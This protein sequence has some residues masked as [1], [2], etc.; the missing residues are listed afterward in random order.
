M[1]VDISAYEIN[2]QPAPAEAFTAAACDPRY[3]VVVEACAGSGKTWLLVA[4]MLRLLLAGAK[5]AELLAITFTRKAAQEMRE[6]LMEL[7]HE[8]TLAPAEQARQLLRERGVSES[9]LARVMPLARSLYEQILSGQQSLSIDTFHSWFAR[10]LQLAPLASGVPHGY[11]LTDKNGELMNEAYRRFMQAIQKPAQREQKDAL[12]A[13]YELAGDSGA[14]R[15]LDAFLDKRAE[16]WAATMPPLSSDDAPLRWLQDLC[17]ND[18]LQD[19]RLQVWQDDTLKA[20]LL[21]VAAILGK[22][23]SANQ[24]RA[25]TI[26]TLVS[27]EAS[28]ENFAALASQFYDDNDKPRGNNT[29]TK[30]LKAALAAHFS[31]DEDQAVTLFDDLFDALG[32]TLRDLQLRSAEKVVVGLNAALF[33]AGRTYLDAYQEVKA[34]QRVFDFADLEW[35]AYRLLT[36]E[37]TAA[38]LQSRLDARYKHILLDEF[39]DTNPLQWSIV[40]AWLRAY[41]DDTMQP[42]V[43][44]VGD[45]KQSIY[46]FRRAEPRVF[47]AARS[48]LEQ[49]GALVLRANQTRRNASAIVGFLNTS[50]VGRNPLFAAQTTLGL[51]GGAVWRLPLVQAPVLDET[52]AVTSATS[53]TALR[54]PLTTPRDEEDD[55][56]RRDEGRLVAQAILQ[57]RRQLRVPGQQG[58]RSLKWSD[59]MLLVKKRR[60]L[61]SYE[62][63]LREAGI[64]FISDKRGGLLDALEIADLIALLNFLI[65]PNDTRALAHVLKSPIIG[66]SDRDL[67]V[68][69][70]RPEPH[71]W[72]RLQAQYRLGEATPPMARAATLLAQWLQAAPRY[73]V[74]DLLDM[75]LHQGQLVARYAQSVAPAMRAQTIGNIESFVELALNLDAGRFPSLPK[76]IDALASLQRHADSD[77]PD[78]ASVDAAADAV[79][80]LTVHSAKGLEAPVVIM[81]DTNHSDPATDNIGIL[82]DWPQDQ[83]APTHFSAFGRKSER[84]LARSPWFAAE[85][86]FRTQE[87]WN[88]LYVAITRA[89]QLLIVSGVA[90]T[91]GALAGGEQEGSWYHRLFDRSSEEVDYL[92]VQPEAT[93]HEAEHLVSETFSLSLF[94]PVPC[95]P[96]VQ[97]VAIDNEAIAEGVALH[98]LLERVTHTQAGWPVKLPSP[99]EIARWLPCSLVLA[100][101]VRAQ[102]QQM[103]SQVALERFFNPNLYRFARNEMEIVT[104]QGVLRCDRVVVF[105]SEVWVLD[106]KRKLLDS[107]RSAY[108]AQLTGYRGAL[109]PLFPDKHIKSALITADGNLWEQ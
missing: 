98:G 64:P 52:D 80:I 83:D 1:T 54:N 32:S 86:G 19:A 30:A 27:G 18:A 15:L 56:R 13:L 12:L 51:Q 96:A 24:K 45:P 61:M 39:Q 79:R 23:A 71:W 104:V 31:V 59:V 76:F 3:S 106:Y 14:K 47:Q 2:A 109:A 73:P 36:N 68:L 67:I 8:L 50:F 81:L 95:P 66:A 75:I 53:V 26:E 55:A 84:G 97:P 20:R 5:P 48:L 58:E 91:R 43:F 105:D 21:E 103:L 10:L 40:R 93:D 92:T 77:A 107:E 70:Q 100:T 38:Y 46:R 101:T 29:R 16:W 37:A 44:V 62:A 35:H 74:H 34:E 88:L 72:Q 42:T 33:T 25:I 78:E 94:E 11:T 57:A 89:K 9:E 69:A 28:P 87:D 63:A 90:S 41:G 49:Q 6:R 7:L 102:A 65:T 17:G 82:C 60:H 85:D 4:R 108:Q 22:G 99:S